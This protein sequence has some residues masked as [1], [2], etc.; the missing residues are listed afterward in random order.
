MLCTYDGTSDGYVS[1][2]RTATEKSHS[3]NTMQGATKHRATYQAIT[4]VSCLMDKSSSSWR[5]DNSFRTQSLRP[6]PEYRAGASPWVILPQK[7]VF[8]KIFL[9]SSSYFVIHSSTVIP[10]FP[11][12][13]AISPPVLVPATSWNTLCGRNSPMVGR[14]LARDRLIWTIRA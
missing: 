9:E 8:P 14:R 12:I 11:S 5:S 7:C 2:A 3:K 13:S 4:S 1:K 6:F 10:I